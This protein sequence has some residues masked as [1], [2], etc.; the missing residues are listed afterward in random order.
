MSGDNSEFEYGFSLFSA[1]KGKP[2]EK[3][4]FTDLG[5]IE[6]SSTKGV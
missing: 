5:T 3:A 6:A 2:S 1:M 4:K